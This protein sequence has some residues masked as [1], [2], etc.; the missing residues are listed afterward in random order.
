MLTCAI[1]GSKGVLGSKLKKKIPLK[2]YEFH[3]NILNKKK[4]NQW[5]QKKDFDILIHLAALVPTNLVNKNYKKAYEVNV[6]GTNNLINS[7]IKK[8]NKPKWLFFSSTSHVYKPLDKFKK[9][10]E[11]SK[12]D[13]ASK[14]GKTKILAEKLILKKLKKYPIKVCIGR[15]FSFT[16]KKKKKPFIIPTIKKKLKNSKKKIVFKNINH[17]RDFLST[18]DIISAIYILM[19]TSKFG[20]YNI[21]SGKKFDLRKIVKL[22]NK[23]NKDIV[24]RNTERPTYLISNNN[25]LLKTKWCPSKFKDNIK[26]FY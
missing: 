8:E 9:I 22:F 4:V 24:F 23:N 16:E 17:F 3:G 25:K 20:I 6:I 21:G 7:L 26:Y 2:F 11:K 10:S 19:K 18:D 5:I 13:P 12:L 1:T 14:Y 15:I